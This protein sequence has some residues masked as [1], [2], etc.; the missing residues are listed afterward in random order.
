[1]IKKANA[2]ARIVVKKPAVWAYSIAK[3]AAIS[4]KISPKQIIVK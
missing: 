2:V 3:L 4:I 1:M